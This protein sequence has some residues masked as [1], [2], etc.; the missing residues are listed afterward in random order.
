MRRAELKSAEAL[1][2]RQITQNDNQGS[3]LLI[4]SSVS[5]GKQQFSV[6]RGAGDSTGAARLRL[7]PTPLDQ[8]LSLRSIQSQN[9]AA[10][11]PSH[12]NL[13]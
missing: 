10:I 2:W 9:A 12:P 6:W 11:A 13:Y 7:R 1:R 3:N 5:L 8:R 4:A